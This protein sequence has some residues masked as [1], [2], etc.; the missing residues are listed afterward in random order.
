MNFTPTCR[1]TPPKKRP[2]R[3]RMF[4][5]R[6][7][8]RGWESSVESYLAQ[9][10]ILLETAKAFDPKLIKTER[11]FRAV[12]VELVDSGLV[13]EQ[14]NAASIRP[15]DDLHF[16][17]SFAIMEF[18]SDANAS[19]AGTLKSRKGSGWFNSRLFSDRAS[20]AEKTG[21]ANHRKLMNEMYGD[22]AS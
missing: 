5:L 19:C 20:M 13:W 4:I 3:L 15:L 10:P 17:P 14:T 8:I 2:V 21:M 12:M 22:S 18:L 6:Q 1:Y 7:V 11:D 9:G 16:F